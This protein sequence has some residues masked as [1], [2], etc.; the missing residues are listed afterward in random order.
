MVRSILHMRSA[1]RVSLS[2]SLSLA[3]TSLSPGKETTFSS[4]L[5]PGLASGRRRP[6]GGEPRRPSIG[7]RRGGEPPSSRFVYS[8]AMAS[9]SLRVALDFLPQFTLCP[10]PALAAH[11]KPPRLFGEGQQGKSTRGTPTKINGQ[12]PPQEILGNIHFRKSAENN[13][14]P[15]KNE[16]KKLRRAITLTLLASARR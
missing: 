4:L 15:L 13:N 12:P 3:S 6:R 16:S 7:V 5:A 14:I 11:A 1:R 8:P 9:V 2:L 10:S